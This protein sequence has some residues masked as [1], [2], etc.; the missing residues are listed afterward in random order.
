MYWIRY[1][2]AYPDFNPGEVISLSLQS[3][4]DE[5][6]R[7]YAA[8]FPAEEYLQGARQ[9]PS[10][11]PIIPDDPAI[12]A[13]RAAWEVLRALDKP[14]I[15]AFSDADPV[16]AGGHVRFQEEVPG[17]RGQRHTTIKGAGHFLQDD[18]P[19][20]LSQVIVDFI[21]DNPARQ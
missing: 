20:A 14:L 4:D 17:A 15:T 9:F 8:P 7:A 12:P 13:N 21:R 6:R 3:C 18:A 5:E 11:V 16:T 19:D 1:C 10:L 2:D